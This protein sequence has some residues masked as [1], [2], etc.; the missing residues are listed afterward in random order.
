[1]NKENTDH[2]HVKNVNPVVH[3]PEKPQH[4]L[5][6]TTDNAKGISE[7]DGLCSPSHKSRSKRSI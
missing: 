2:S 4:K 3:A 7:V 6:F 1:M 5:S